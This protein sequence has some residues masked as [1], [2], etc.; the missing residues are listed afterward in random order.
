F[1]VIFKKK[2]IPNTILDQKPLS[3]CSTWLPKIVTEFS[4]V[5]KTTSSAIRTIKQGGVSIDGV[6]I[7]DPNKELDAGEYT[8]KVGKKEFFKIVVR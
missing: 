4:E 2:E 8:L 6:K 3:A 7:T 5:N 1:D